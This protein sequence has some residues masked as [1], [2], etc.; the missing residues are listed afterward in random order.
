MMTLVVMAAGMG[1]RFG[2]SK[3]TAG[4][5]IFIQAFFITFPGNKHRKFPL[6][7]VKDQPGCLQSAF[8]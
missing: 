6:K 8:G 1:S 5:G 7:T 3:Q 2:G 4:V